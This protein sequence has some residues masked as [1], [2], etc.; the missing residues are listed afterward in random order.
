MHDYRDAALILVAHGSTLN[1]DSAAPA[2]FHADALRRRGVFGEVTTAFLLQEP[3]VAGALRRVF[4]RR[5]FIV[6]FF[7][8][9]GWFSLQVVPVELGLR[10]VG[11]PDFPRVQVR[12]GRTV[13]YCDPVGTDP[14]MTDVLLARAEAA[15]RSG[16]P[17]APSDLARVALIVAGH[18]TGYAT[19]SRR[20]VEAQVDRIRERARFGEV[21][22][23]FLEE[24]PGIP[25]AWTLGDA[26]D[27]VLVPFF[28]SDG[29]HTREDIPRLLGES[30]ADVRQ[31]LREGRPTW[32]NPTERQ[33]RRLWYGTALGG[34]PL[35]ADVILAR[36]RE[37]ATREGWAGSDRGLV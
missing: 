15:L 34:E 25:E 18:G 24:S 10:A 5:V 8:S 23:V 21:F 32:G 12:E 2:F 11:D 31:R 27:R 16:G 6:P 33:G 26:A 28:L 9:E 22:G 13:C 35:L 17:G 14:G 1:A 30:E 37:A 7:L 19:G 4:A 36:V 20:S 29:L 3:T